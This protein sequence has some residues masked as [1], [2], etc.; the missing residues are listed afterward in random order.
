MKKNKIYLIIII[1][2]ILSPII[3]N[4]ISVSTLIIKKNSI[5]KIC[6]TPYFVARIDSTTNDIEVFKAYMSK[7]GWN[8]EEQDGGLLKFK[9]GNEK[10]E[11]LVTNIKTIML[12]K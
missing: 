6:F 9:K 12:D 2:I 5:A 10:Q 8:F 4:I 3:I 7:K 11:I 1:L